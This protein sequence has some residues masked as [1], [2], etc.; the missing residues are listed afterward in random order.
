MKV[1]YEKAIEGVHRLVFILLVANSTN[2]LV[3]VW[4]SRTWVLLWEQ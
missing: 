1:G 2:G 4:P 3:P